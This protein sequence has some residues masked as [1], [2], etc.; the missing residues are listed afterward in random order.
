MKKVFT[1]LFVVVALVAMTPAVMFAQEIPDSSSV[2]IENRQGVFF[3]TTTDYY[4]DDLVKSE[5]RKIG[6]TLEMVQ[7]LIGSAF[8]QLS[9]F[10]DKA[11]EVARINKPRQL[12][13]QTSQ[14]GRAHV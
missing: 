2:T 3:R 6:D 12:V 8:P 9:A 4:P 14:I 10:A 13:S 7:A 11:V 1:S 5:T